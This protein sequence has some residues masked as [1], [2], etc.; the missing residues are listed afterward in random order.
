VLYVGDL[1]WNT[2]ESLDV[3][4]APKHNFGWPLFEGLDVL[5]G[6][7]Y[8]G[9]VANL[10]ALNP[11]YPKSGCS[12]YFTFNQLLQEDTLKLTGQPP[13]KNPCRNTRKIPDSIPQFL[14]T[15]SVLDWNHASA[16]TRTPIYDGS[17]RA[18]AANVG[19]SRSPVS[20]T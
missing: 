12:Q 20:G 13:F 10:D 15:R 2:W 14:H 18:R 4:T 19:T 11:L 17:G 7:G 6:D 5:G 8:D 3:V 9:N 16:I 1:G